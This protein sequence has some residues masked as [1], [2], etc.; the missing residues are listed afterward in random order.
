MPSRIHPLPKKLYLGPDK[1]E[2]P[3]IILTGIEFAGKVDAISGGAWVKELN[4]IYLRSDMSLSRRWVAFREELMH[5]LV[6]LS[7]PPV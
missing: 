1:P 7:F 3:V 2:I 6:D 5:A 4:T